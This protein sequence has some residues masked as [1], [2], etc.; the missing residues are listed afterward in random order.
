MK[1]AMVAVF[2]LVVFA[3]FCWLICVWIDNLVDYAR[4]YRDPWSEQLDQ[5]RQLPEKPELF[6]QEAC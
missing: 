5:I 3:F 1:T 6:D 2:V 4:T